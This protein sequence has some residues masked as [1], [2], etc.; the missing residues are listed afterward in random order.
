MLCVHLSPQYTHFAWPSCS[1]LYLSS[2][3]HTLYLDKVYCCTFIHLGLCTNWDVQLYIRY[4]QP[5]LSYESQGIFVCFFLRPL[6]P[7]PS[8]PSLITE[9]RQSPSA[10]CITERLCKN[11]LTRFPGK[12]YGCLQLENNWGLFPYFFSFWVPL[13]LHTGLP[14][15]ANQLW[16][17]LS[18]SVPV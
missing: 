5:G 9:C 12:I 13:C 15:S 7:C 11:Q 1:C 14:V 10:I 6:D 8:I 18:L 17:N 2:L 3:V 16:I 4:C